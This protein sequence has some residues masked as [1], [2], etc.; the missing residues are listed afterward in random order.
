MPHH[1][2]D[3]LSV[4]KLSEENHSQSTEKWIVLSSACAVELHSAKS[5]GGFGLAL[6][7]I[8]RRDPNISSL[9][10][11]MLK[12]TLNGFSSCLRLAILQV[13]FR[14]AGQEGKGFLGPFRWLCWGKNFLCGKDGSMW[15]EGRLVTVA[16]VWL[17][18]TTTSSR[19]PPQFKISCG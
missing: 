14:P 13:C 17:I 4:K 11:N 19:S 8:R 7:A 10:T 3:F 2:K 1:L 6:W 18:S 5:L 16:H 9:S 12:R 15:G